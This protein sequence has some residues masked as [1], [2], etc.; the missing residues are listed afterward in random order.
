MWLFDVNNGDLVLVDL[1]FWVNIIWCCSYW[2]FFFNK[3]CKYLLLLLDDVE[4]FEKEFEERVEDDKVEIF[5][6]GEGSDI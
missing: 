6:D 2:L 4:I 1:V 3:Y 5:L